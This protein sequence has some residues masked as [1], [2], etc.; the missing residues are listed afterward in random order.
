MGV[1]CDIQGSKPL[2]FAYGQI[3]NLATQ[4][5]PTGQFVSAIPTL[6]G[7]IKLLSYSYKNHALS[8]VGVL[9]MQTYNVV[10]EQRHNP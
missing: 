7:V 10:K 4:V 6:D 3:S 2:R 1:I 8:P 9:I 5:T